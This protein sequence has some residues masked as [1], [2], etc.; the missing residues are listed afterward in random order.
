MT[1]VELDGELLIHSPVDVR[2]SLLETLGHPRWVLA[3]NLLHHLYVQP[4]IDA[5]LES[6][7]AP[8][9]AD[10]RPDLRFDH[11][12]ERGGRHPFGNDVWLL[13]LSSFALT[14]EVVMLHRPSGT[15]IVAD[16]VFNVPPTAPWT[17]R[18]AMRALLGYPGC[19][20]TIVERVG[21]DRTK[22]RRELNSILDWPFDRII[23]AHGDIVETGGKD[24][25]RDAFAWLKL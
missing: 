9:L 10:K 11:Q 12:V 16:L 17:T 8:G 2:P 14:N 5:G 19:C 3:P 21:M 13:P 24:A 1:V 18:T 23:M 25:L 20:T 6:W 7:A 15:L 22:A 4:W